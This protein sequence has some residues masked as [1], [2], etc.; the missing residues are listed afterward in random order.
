MDIKKLRK[1]RIVMG[2]IGFDFFRVDKLIGECVPD[3]KSLYEV[4][5]PIH[6]EACLRDAPELSI[7]IYKSVCVTEITSL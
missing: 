5:D 6:H 3:S 4:L 1:I 2:Y 7:Y